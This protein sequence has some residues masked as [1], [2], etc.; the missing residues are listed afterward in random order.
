M[1]KIAMI[2]STT[3]GQ[4]KKIVD[5]LTHRVDTHHSVDM[6]P[7]SHASR[8]DLVSFDKVVLGA[9]IRYGKYKPEVFEFVAGH[10]TLLEEKETFFFSV[11][12]VARKPEKSSAAT[13]P[14]MSKFLATTAWKPNHLEVF[15]GK[16]DYP[17]YGFFDRNII[18]LIMHIT[19]GPT[20]I[21]QCHEFTDWRSVEKFGDLISKTV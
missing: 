10:E 17:K 18:R 5:Q 21:S 14:Y 3:D 4:T 15:A 19:R 16:V 11:N 12:V 7:V 9:S 8:L 2:Y 1:S 20:D 6:A 13:N